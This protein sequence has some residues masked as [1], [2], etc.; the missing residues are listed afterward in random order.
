RGRLT[1]VIVG[2]PGTQRLQSVAGGAAG[3]VAIGGNDR[4]PRRPLVVSSRDGVQ[5][6]PMAGGLF[7]PRGDETLRAYGVTAGPR[8]HVVVGED[9][10]AAVVWHSADLR[11]WRRGK[12]ADKDLDP[13]DDGNRWMQAV[14][15]GPGGYVAV[16][17]AKG[18]GGDHVPVAWT[19]PD[20]LTWTVRKTPV[21]PVGASGYLHHVAVS[22]QV[23]VAAGEY[24]VGDEPPKRFAFASSD[25]GQS[26]Q[27]TMPAGL[28]DAESVTGV[29]ALPQ[30]VAIHGT[31]GAEG[32][33]DVALWVSRDGRT[34]RMERPGET[35][36]SGTGDQRLTGLVTFR[37]GMLAVGAS[38][39]GQGTQPVLWR[40]PAF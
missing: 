18:P 22:G 4:L 11:T 37:G 12:G 5:W 40:R 8:G 13:T 38:T 35:A 3:W 10:S 15:S 21:L 30:G 1:G 27:E 25:G 31:T 6:R 17:G 26:W 28:A 7:A 2:G 32:A 16:G 9:G 23:V 29:S 39:T 20:G 36:L 19:S 34:W 24:R 14:A 33:A